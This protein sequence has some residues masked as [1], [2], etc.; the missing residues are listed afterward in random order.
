MDTKR[1]LRALRGAPAPTA[2]PPPPAEGDELEASPPL[3]CTEREIERWN[4]EWFEYL[5][6]EW[7]LPAHPLH[8]LSRP[9]AAARLAARPAA[10]AARPRLAA[11]PLLRP[12]RPGGAAGDGDGVR[13]RQPRQAARPLRGL[14][15][16]H[17]LQHPG[18]EDRPAGLPRQLRLRPRRRPRRARALLRHRS[19]PSSAATSG[20]IRTSSSPAGT[21]SSWRASSSPAAGSTPTSTGPTPRPSRRSSS[22]PTI[23]SPRPTPRP[24][25]A[26][27]A[28]TSAG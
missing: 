12:R 4:A 21:W 14:L 19:T 11:L 5:K 28:R 16:R 24:P 15:S 22:R 3:E 2:P 10:P 20:S 7:E 17:R 25:S 18:A 6:R 27:A 8:R 23:R 9:A 13:L 1:L 26:T